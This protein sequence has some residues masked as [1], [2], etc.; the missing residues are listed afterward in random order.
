M[1]PASA[2]TASGEGEDSIAQSSPVA[3]QYT[4]KAEKKA[5]AS[6][7]KSTRQHKQT[8]AQKAAGPMLQ[9]TA[10]DLLQQPA[11]A[12]LQDAAGPMLQDAAGAVLQDAVGPVLQDA[13]GAMMQ[14]EEAAAQV[15]QQQVHKLN[16][17]SWQ[18]A[19]LL[20]A[21]AALPKQPNA[22]QSSEAAA[23]PPR[24]AAGNIIIIITSRQ[25][26]Q[27]AGGR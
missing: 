22:A 1:Q 24:A 9:E 25:L 17:F 5:F 15:G 6:G 12:V 3:V 2:G 19:G 11:G 13:A 14:E 27:R 18:A 7:G 26:R 16:R 10:W 4:P 23:G 21:P 20:R 8:T